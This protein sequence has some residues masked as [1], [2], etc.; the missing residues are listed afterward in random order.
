MLEICPL[1]NPIQHYDWGSVTAIPE[2]L[3]RP[4]SERPVAEV[5]L[6]AHP[7]APSEVWIEN[8]WDDLRQVLHRDPAG[9]LGADGPPSVDISGPEDGS[10]AS[11]ARLPFLL[12]ILAAGKPLS[13][14]AH[15]N[16][17]QARLGFERE[18]KAGIPRWDAKRNYR[19]RNHKPEIIY[20]VTP[21]TVL[22]GFRPAAE[23]LELFDRFGLDATRMDA[24]GT[25][26]VELRQPLAS[27]DASLHAFFKAFLQAD[28]DKI[29]A[30]VERV[31]SRAARMDGAEAEW[32][33]RM[34]GEFPADRGVLSPLFL[35]LRTLEPGEV[36]YTGPGVLHAYLHGLGIELMANSDNVLR[37]AC[38]SKHVDADELLRILEP[39]PQRPCFIKPTVQPGLERFAT[40]SGELCLSIIRVTEHAPFVQSA[41]K[42]PQI[43]L[44]AEG[45]GHITSAAGRRV[46]FAR[47]TSFVVP[48]CAD[49]YRIEGRGVLFLAE[50]GA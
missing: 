22:C 16:L 13:I 24:T 32:V 21:F 12:K 26:A 33:C 45:N 39:S 42:R 6:G 30:W 48:A 41:P 18:E 17:E 27:G 20:A 3:G 11:T 40:P 4:P 37:G 2:F 50:A 28:A 34:A 19:D 8:G 38:T 49:Q 25:D 14:Q 31:T 23:I 15:P 29:A 9:W 7:K 46:P 43:L 1:R 35:N 5:W 47:D 10:D 44:C 36:V